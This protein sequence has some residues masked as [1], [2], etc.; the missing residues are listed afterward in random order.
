MSSHSSPAASRSKKNGQVLAS[1]AAPQGSYAKP[2]GCLHD[3]PCRLDCS[4]CAYAPGTRNRLYYKVKPYVPRRLRTLLRGTLAARVRARASQVWPIDPQAVRPPEGW[5]GWPDGKRFAVVLTHDVEGVAGLARVQELAALE[6]R[7]GFTSSFN[8]IPE[9]EYRVTR[10]LREELAGRGFEVGVHDLFHNGELFQSDRAFPSR[11][12]KINHYLKE[13]SASGFR[14]GFMLRNLDWIQDL[15]ILYDASTF[16]TDPFE[17]QPYGAR[18]IF[19]FY[20]DG[21]QGRRGYVE[22]PYT[23][24][25]DSTLFLLLREPGI[26]IWRTKADWLAEQGGMVLL[27]LHPDYV[28]FGNGEPPAG[29]Y[30]ARHYE[31]LLRYIGERYAGQFWSPLPKELAMWYVQEVARPGRR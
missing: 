26:D 28:W 14:A 20:I 25:Q 5:R 24:V 29:T 7:C 1:R 31:D 4:W 15:N 12:R 11:A 8:F 16:D 19:P 18:T 3:G 9:G 30:P 10:E 13:W 22:L 2:P 17:P 27:N 21:T 23:L 6:R